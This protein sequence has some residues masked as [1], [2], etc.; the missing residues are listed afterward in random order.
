MQAAVGKITGNTS[1]TIRNSSAYVAAVLFNTI[2]EAGSD[3]LA[4]P[5]LNFLRQN[6]KGGG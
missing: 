4:D 1:R 2:M 6:T 5:Y 3:L